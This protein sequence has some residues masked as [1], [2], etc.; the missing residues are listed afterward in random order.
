MYMPN[1]FIFL[2]FVRNFAIY[3]SINGYYQLKFR[4]LF[5]GQTL[6]LGVVKNECFS[7]SINVV[8]ILYQICLNERIHNLRID[9]KALV[10][11]GCYDSV[12]IDER[13]PK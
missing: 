7:I 8:T 6:Q 2:H 12:I 3:A 10:N 5:H 4:S 11:K 1:S 13:M 9:T